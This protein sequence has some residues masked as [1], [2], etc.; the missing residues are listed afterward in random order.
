[1]SNIKGKIN[2]EQLDP[3]FIENIKNI[4][5]SLETVSKKVETINK[6]ENLSVERLDKD[7]NG[8][9]KTLQ[10]K[11]AKK[12]LVKKSLLSGGTSPN[13]STRTEEYYENSAIIKTI[14]YTLTYDSDGILISEV[15]KNE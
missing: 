1:M 11:N 6:K 13:Y 14:K 3:K 10:F 9:F 12:E 5:V 8:I 7:E 2:E 15:I 4:N